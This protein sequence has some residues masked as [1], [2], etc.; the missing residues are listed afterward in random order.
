LNSTREVPMSPEPWEYEPVPIDPERDELNR[1]SA[2]EI[3]REKERRMYFVFFKKGR[4]AEVETLPPAS[5][6]TGAVAF[7]VGA[8]RWLKSIDSAW[9]ALSSDEGELATLALLSDRLPAAVDAAIGE[10]QKPAPAPA[11]P[12]PWNCCDWQTR[13][14]FNWTGNLSTR[15]GENCVDTKNRDGPLARARHAG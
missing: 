4:H 5:T 3:R 11:L 8:K 7:Y 15:T 2:Y 13:H 12:D 6:C 1:E 10:A 14:W 9:F